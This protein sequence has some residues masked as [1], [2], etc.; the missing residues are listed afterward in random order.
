MKT[1]CLLSEDAELKTKRFFEALAMIP[2]SQGHFL[3]KAK[4]GGREK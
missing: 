3:N 2:V 4:A 1:R